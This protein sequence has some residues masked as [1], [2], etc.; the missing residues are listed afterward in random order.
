MD[1]TIKIVFKDFNPPAGKDR[2]KIAS[3]YF[4]EWT[5]E[6]GLP[7][8]INPAMRVSK[9]L[10]MQLTDSGP[11]LLVFS[12]YDVPQPLTRLKK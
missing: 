5:A 3:E 12:V 11:D 10:E 8:A 1:K 4:Q 6:G 7:E 9:Q 2:T